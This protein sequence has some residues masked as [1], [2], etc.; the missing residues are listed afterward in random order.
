[1]LPDDLPIVAGDKI[2]VDKIGRPRRWDVVVFKTPFEVSVN[3]AKRLIA[4]PGEKV[5]IIGGEVFINDRLEAKPFGVAH[6][7]WISVNDTQL[8]PGR[9]S[10]DQP[11]WKP[12]PRQS[13]WSWNQRGWTFAGADVDPQE[14]VFSGPITDES[15]YSERWSNDSQRQDELPLESGDVQ[16][17]CL[18]TRFSGNGP[19][20]FRWRSRSRE[21]AATVTGSGQIEL[22]SDHGSREVHLLAACAVARFAVEK[23]CRQSTGAIIA[24]PS[25]RAACRPTPAGAAAREAL[26]RRGSR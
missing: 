12:K 2:L 9:P 13:K 5:E 3:Y 7:L 20:G 21:A 25:T 8:R 11:Q 26:V 24:T 22:R 1:L 23:R 18:L 14:L 17:T 19:L 4:V 6:D 16:V 15:S 10:A